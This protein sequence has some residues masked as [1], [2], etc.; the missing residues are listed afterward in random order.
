MPRTGSVEPAETEHYA[1][2]TGGREAVRADFRSQIRQGHR[3]LSLTLFGKEEKQEEKEIVLTSRRRHL[4]L[5]DD[6]YGCIHRIMGTVAGT[7]Q[8]VL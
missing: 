7:S 3:A 4:S 2:A 6:L 8:A 5:E 1:R